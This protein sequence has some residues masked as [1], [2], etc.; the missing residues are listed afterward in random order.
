MISTRYEDEAMKKLLSLA[1]CFAIGAL[2]F[3]CSSK[4]DPTGPE[5]ETPEKAVKDIEMIKQFN[6]KH[7]K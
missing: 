1:I 6:E 5:G 2:T 7:K 4:H 3:G